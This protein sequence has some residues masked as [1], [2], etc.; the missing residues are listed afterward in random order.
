[1]IILKT[2]SGRGKKYINL[3]RSIEIFSKIIG[4][5]ISIKYNEKLTLGDVRGKVVYTTF[6]TDKTNNDGT[7]IHN[8]RVEKCTDI[9]QIHR[10]LTNNNL[11]YQEFKVGGKLKVQEIKDLMKTY[12][13][14]FEDAEERQE[15]ESGIDFPVKY[16]TSCTGEFTRHF[17]LPKYE[18]KIINNFLINNDFKKGYYYGWISVDFIDELITQKII[19]SNFVEK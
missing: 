11:K 17:P 13:L 12:T 14:S 1:M 5:D 3:K 16:E 19:N 6:L 8:T 15:K 7:P 2:E 18:A 9:I 4:K 10:K